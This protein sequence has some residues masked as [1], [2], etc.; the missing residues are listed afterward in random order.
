MSLFALWSF[1]TVLKKSDD[2]LKSRALE[3]NSFAAKYVAKTVT[4]ELE[5]RYA[6]VDD[7]A[8]SHRFQEILEA[9][10]NDPELA[11]LR[12]QLSDPDLPAEKREALRAEFVA[13]P[14]RQA[15]QHRLDELLSD[16]K[17]PQAAS[18]FVTD[19]TGLQLARAPDGST[20]GFNFAW[21][22]YFN[23]KGEDM[24][25]SW[26][27]SPDEHIKKTT[28]SSVFL[29]SAVNRWSVAISTPILKDEDAKDENA[30]PRFLGVMG[31]TVEVGHFVE[32][33]RRAEQFAV[34]VDMRPG[35]DRGLILEHP[36]FDKLID[37]HGKVPDRFLQYRLQ[38][39]RL[40]DGSKER[41]ANYVDPLGEDPEGGEYS[42]HW[43]AGVANV[44]L[45]DGN[46]GWQV[47]VQEPYD[48]AIGRTLDDL[49]S[50]LWLSGLLALAV[51]A[52]LSTALWSFVIRVLWSKAA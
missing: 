1:E 22:S 4:N 40:L 25:S 42:K 35:N 37:E 38:G 28:L 21:R 7:M 11:R 51:I 43:L 8:G 6:S 46:T 41:G 39:D 15:L 48:Q 32:L 30:A 12:A 29:S 45:V 3:I 17:E 23:S 27:A 52:V 50:G 5:R 47:I 2:T 36:L 20:I 13:H 26:R 14:A 49:R 24:P 9:A 31:M 18:W 34:L 44:S 33:N 16:E 19:S 10:L